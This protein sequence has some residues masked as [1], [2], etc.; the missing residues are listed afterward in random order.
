MISSC[1]CHFFM[2]K[3]KQLVLGIMY[4]VLSMKIG[5]NASFLNFT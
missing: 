1:Q 3:Y 2:L 4:Q 5:E